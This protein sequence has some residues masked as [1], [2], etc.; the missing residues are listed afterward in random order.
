MVKIDD[1]NISR[2]FSEQEK[3]N[4]NKYILDLLN[5]NSKDGSALVKLSCIQTSEDI[6]LMATVSTKMIS[7][8]IRVNARNKSEVIRKFKIHFSREIE[9]N[10]TK[11]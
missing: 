1:K 5:K 7:I 11:L 8:K 9:R 10:K 3:D 4:L 6:T 2:I